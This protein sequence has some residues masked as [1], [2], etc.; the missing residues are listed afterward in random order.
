MAA[1]TRSIERT[2]E[3]ELE[4][5]RNVIEVLRKQNENMK[6]TL[7]LKGLSDAFELEGQPGPRKK[8]K[9]QK[10][11]PVSQTQASDRQ[12]RSTSRVTPEISTEPEVELN[13]PEGQE[14]EVRKVTAMKSIWGRQNKPKLK[15]EINE[16][17][18]PCVVLG[19]R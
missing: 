19:I 2:P 15:L 6:R 18:Q 11:T 13:E 17:G 7:N 3:Y 8:K 9:R 16:Y 4:K 1:A 12:L 10:R 14:R 5:N